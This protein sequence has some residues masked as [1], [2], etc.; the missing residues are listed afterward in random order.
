M[1]LSKKG[2]QIIYAAY[3][4]ALIYNV[5]GLSFAVQGILS[6]VIAAILMP[7]SSVTIVAFGWG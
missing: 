1:Q 6:P 5:I 2:I 3:F 4:P 7:L